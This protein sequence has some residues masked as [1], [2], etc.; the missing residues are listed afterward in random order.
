MA[1]GRQLPRPEVGGGAG[2]HADQARR[3]APEEA[4]ELTPAEL[5]ADQNLSFLINTV[6]LEDV[7]GEI[8]TNQS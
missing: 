7:L 1:K 6:D 8:E 5:P 3:Q 2:L 4:D